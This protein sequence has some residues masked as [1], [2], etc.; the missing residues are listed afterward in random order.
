[1]NTAKL[2][3]RNLESDL[4]TSREAERAASL[5]AQALEADSRLITADRDFYVKEL[6]QTRD[7]WQKFRTESVGL[8]YLHLS[9]ELFHRLNVVFYDPTP[10]LFGEIPLRAEGVTTYFETDLTAFLP[11]FESLA[12]PDLSSTKR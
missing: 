5:R 1:M 4:T 2:T 3:I 11:T 10:L 8:I 9:N 12:T 6:D 7:G